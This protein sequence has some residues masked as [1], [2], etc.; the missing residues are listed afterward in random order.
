[1]ELADPP[2]LPYLVLEEPWM[3]M[4]TLAGV[5]VVLWVIGGQRA[6]RRL[7][8][9]SLGLIAS[10]GGVYVLATVVQTDRERLITAT[11]SLVEATAPLDASTIRS[12][13]GPHATLSGPDGDPWL[14]AGELLDEL[15]SALRRYEVEEHRIASVGA[16][17][18]DR[19]GR[20]VL[21]LRTTM[22]DSVYAGLPVRTVWVL[23]WTREPDGRW[24]VSDLRWM[25]VNGQR[26]N[27]GRWW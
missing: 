2:I 17:A 12:R 16:E 24:R 18:G 3:L 27:A 4:L 14:P 13:L 5:G 10:S 7:R 9:A 26:P 19:V 23:T 1:M 21:D 25:Q 20:S 22:E 6:S 11:Q 8:W 15:E